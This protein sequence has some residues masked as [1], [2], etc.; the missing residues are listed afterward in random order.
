MPDTKVGRIVHI[1]RGYTVAEIVEPR[2]DGEHVVGYSVFGYRSDTSL[3]FETTERALQVLQEVADAWE[4]DGR[5]AQRH[6]P[7]NRR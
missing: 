6:N 7:Q 5:A 2:A 4:A 3:V 1:S